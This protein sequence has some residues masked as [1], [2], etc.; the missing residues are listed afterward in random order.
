MAPH[1]ATTIKK[2]PSGSNT[3]QIIKKKPSGS[4]K[5]QIVKKKPSGSAIIAGIKQGASHARSIADA[6]AADD[7]SPWAAGKGGR[8]ASGMVAGKGGNGSGK[9]AVGAGGAHCSHRYSGYDN[10][11]GDFSLRAVAPTW[12]QVIPTKHSGNRYDWHLSGLVLNWTGI[13]REPAPAPIPTEP[14]S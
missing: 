7:A 5:Q 8:A 11:T 14:A 6:N 2:K 4:S 10:G 12:Q 3:Q 13:V 9:G 1:S